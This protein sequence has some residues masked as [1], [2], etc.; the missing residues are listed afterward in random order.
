ME[1]AFQEKTLHLLNKL[2]ERR[3]PRNEIVGS[4]SNAETSHLVS[5]RGEH[6]EPYSDEQ[7][8]ALKRD[9]LKEMFSFV[10]CSIIITLVFFGL[11]LIL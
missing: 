7:L 3:Q 5:C 2:A 11:V 10:G 6:P 8:K 4:T 1:N 9:T